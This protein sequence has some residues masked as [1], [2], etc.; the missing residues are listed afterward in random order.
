MNTCI[1]SNCTW[2][3]N[4]GS[5]LR[6]FEPRIGIVSYCLSGCNLNLM[7]L[8]LLFW[9][10]GCL[11]IPLNCWNMVL[12]QAKF[13]ILLEDMRHNFQISRPMHAAS[14]LYIYTKVGSM[15]DVWLAVVNFPFK[16]LKNTI[17]KL[18]FELQWLWFSCFGWIYKSCDRTRGA[19]L[20]PV[21]SR[22]TCCL[23]S[24]GCYCNIQ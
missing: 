13:G 4:C 18:D 9:L 15:K 22:Q 14:V 6:S 21:P 16:E 5:V 1:L 11:G 24:F 17:F 7:W 23:C 19:K 8:F 2:L 3:V 10:G 20:L 12:I